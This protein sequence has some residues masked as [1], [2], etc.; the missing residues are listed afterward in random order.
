MPFPGGETM[1][2]T[3]VDM[4]CHT[5]YSRDSV[6]PPDVMVKRYVQRG[7]HAVCVTDHNTIEGARHVQRIAPF[8]VVIGE[9]ISSADGEIIGLFLQ[10]TI[11]ASLSSAD[12]VAAIHEQGG[13]AVAPHPF[14]RRR[15]GRLEQ[16][17]L[18]NIRF[19]LDIVEVFNSRTFLMSD[20]ER[21][22]S[23]ARANGLPM[24]AGSDAH[25]PGEIGTAYVD[26]PEFETAAEFIAS[27]RQ[28]VIVGRRSNP[29]LRLQTA[30]TRFR[31]SPLLVGPSEAI[32]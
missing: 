25:T 30:F 17:A 16:G 32:A 19:T 21:T 31:R 2:L 20:N 14:D 8:Q 9:E 13:L 23:W 3:R 27:L 29:L 22:A 10:E 7:I 18:Q 6:I 24:G 1:P 4:H 5:T 28:G 12:T 15:G 26:M 11:P